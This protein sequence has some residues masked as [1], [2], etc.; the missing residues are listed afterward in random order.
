[1]QTVVTVGLD[2]AKN[3]FQAHGVGADGAVIFRKR[4]TRAK[5]AE[6]FAG[7]PP[8]LVGIE[9]CATAHHW[10]RTL[11]SFGHTVKLMPPAYVKPYVK[12]RRTMP[13]TRRRSARPLRGPRCG[14]PR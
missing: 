3:V 5:V 14:S 4:L 9:A 8:C 13:P 12:A 7:L 2:I 1:M 6:F 11:Q 10:A